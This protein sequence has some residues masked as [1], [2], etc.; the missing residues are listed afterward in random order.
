MKKIDPS[1]L[2]ITDMRFADIDGAPKRCTLLKLFTNQGLVGYGEVRDASSRTYAAM[3]K[4]RILGENPCNVERIFRRIKQFGG[5]SRQAGGVSGIEV[6]LWDLAGKAW[7]V[8]V[9]QLLGGKFRDTIRIYCDTDS[10]GGGRDMG[11]ALKARIDAGFTFLKMDLGIELLMDKPGCLS[12]PLG[13]LEKMR[14]Y[15]KTVFS[16]PHGSIDPRAMKGEAYELFSTPHPLTGIHFTENGLDFLEKYMSEVRE[17][18]G[19]GIPLAVDHLGHIPVEDCLKLAKRLERFNLA[20]MEDPVPWQMT[21]QYVRLA[22]STTVPIATGEDIFLKE[23]FKPLFESR[24]ISVVHPDV[25]TAGGILETKK[26]GDMAEDYGIAM[27]IHMAESPIACMAAVH[28]AAAT[29][30]FMALEVHSVDV[31]WWE[32]LVKGLPKP[33][34]VNGCIRVPDAPGLGIE[35]LNED[36]IKEKLHNDFAVAWAPTDMWNKEWANDRQ[37]S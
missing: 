21:N 30:N 23:S 25:L 7:G 5:H 9:W 15:K 27:A 20:W 36:L 1:K 12:A 3:L 4:S 18:I 37:W 14:E 16:T 8:P 26:I 6:A 31:P 19:Y 17:V 2:V 11:K 24:G 33:L 13:F 10:S 22:N 28:A 32:D 35:S 34:I 29:R